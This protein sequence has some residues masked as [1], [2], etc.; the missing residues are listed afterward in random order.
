MKNI[1][2]SI[3]KESRMVYGY[4]VEVRQEIGWPQGNYTEEWYEFN[5]KKEALDFARERETDKDCT[6]HSV[7]DYESVQRNYD[8]IDITNEMY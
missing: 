2:K 6:V 5:T 3:A 1:V 7:L 8:P 4:N